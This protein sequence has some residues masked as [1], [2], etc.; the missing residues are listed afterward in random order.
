M[1][2]DTISDYIGEFKFNISP[3]SFFQVNPMQTEVLYKKG[4]RICKSYRKRGCI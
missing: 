2:K 1:G 4:I 3:L